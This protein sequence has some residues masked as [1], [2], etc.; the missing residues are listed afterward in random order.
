MRKGRWN[1]RNRERE[2]VCMH[3]MGGSR[4]LQGSLDRGGY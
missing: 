3:E 4:G 2:G 1:F